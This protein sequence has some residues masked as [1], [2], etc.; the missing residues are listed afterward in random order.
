MVLFTAW[1]D[2]D[3]VW[4]HPRDISISKAPLAVQEESQILTVTFFWQKH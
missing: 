3:F 1:P 4:L 2:D